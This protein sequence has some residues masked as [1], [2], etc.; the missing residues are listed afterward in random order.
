MGWK[1]TKTEKDLYKKCL[2]PKSVKIGHK[3]LFAFSKMFLLHEK[4][5]Q[6]Q[7]NF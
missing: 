2:H 5:Q 3:S 1:T 7:N 6:S 4:K